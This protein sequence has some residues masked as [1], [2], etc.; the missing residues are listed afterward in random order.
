MNQRRR[1]V[2]EEEEENDRWRHFR[3]QGT[4]INKE[5]N[6]LW[7]WAVGRTAKGDVEK[8]IRR[9]VIFT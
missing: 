7:I 1:W 2:D 4:D 9:P 6:L 5:Q 3:R 8:S